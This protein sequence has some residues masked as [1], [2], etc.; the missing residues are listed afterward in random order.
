M[1]D[2]A[3][4]SN[5]RRTKEAILRAEQKPPT[6]PVELAGIPEDLKALRQW[7]AWQWERRQGKW[8]KVP[9]NART[10]KRASPTDPAT[11]EPFQSA[12]GHYQRQHLG[13]VGF[14]FAA[15]DPFAG[16]DLD[17]CRDLETGELQP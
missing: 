14:V 15:D 4:P 9:I 16:V 7:V 12:L 13:G 17:E 1:P 11:W 6:F 10:G 5:T 2:T 3:E 8:T